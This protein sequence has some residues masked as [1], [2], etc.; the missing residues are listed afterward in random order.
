VVCYAELVVGQI[1]VG[2][3]QLPPVVIGMLVLIL[4]TQAILTRV[5]DRLR[6]HPHEL[7][8]IYVMMLLASMISSRGLLQKLVPLLVVPNYLAT[9]D[10]GWKTHFYKFIRPWSVP[11][12]PKGEPKQ[13]VSARFYEGL[14]FGEHIPWHLWLRPLFSWGV[15]ITLIFTAYLCLA[16]ILRRQWVDN[17]KLAFPLVQLPLEMVRGQSSDGTSFLTNR[18]TWLGFLLPALLFGFNGLHQWYPSIPDVATDIDLNALFHDRPWNG[19]TY[20][21]IYLSLAALGFFYLLPTDLLFSFWFFFL[22]TKVEEVG[23]SALGYEPNI[24]PLAGCK[25]FIG[26][27]IIGCYFVL[28]GTMIYSARSHLKRVWRHAI[29]FG[30]GGCGEDAGE[31]FSYRT[32]FWGLAACVLLSAGWMSLLGMAYWL[33]LI[34]LCILIFIVA[35]VMARSTCEGG[36]LMTETSF[37]PVDIF[38]MFGDVRN[39]GG[40]NLTCMAFLDGLLMRDLRGL[41]LTGFLDSMK[42][43]DGVRVRRRSLLGVFLLSFAVALGVSGC[44][45]IVLPYHRGAIT[46]YSYVYRGNPVWAFNDASSV[47]AGQRPPLSISATI[48]CGIGVIITLAMAALRAQLPW[49]PFHPLGYALSGSW[50]VMVFWFPCLVAWFCKGVILRYGGKR[51][52]LILRPFFLGLVLGEFTMAVLWTIPSLFYNT[53]TPSFPWP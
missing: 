28:V 33:A 52:Y 25:E 8:T 47:L 26:Y 14:R 6:L 4:G 31:L 51:L 19:M 11:F 39:L 13:F 2:F 35:L 40:G 7:F 23:A 24:M 36:M 38:R 22:L 12:D 37:R 27:Q 3:L 21:H 45:H 48:W 41:I 30:R 53:P 15:F 17:E 46:M 50:S 18:L 1:Q 9:D 44:L 16:V 10:N 32:A 20:F 34:E 43:A 5:N 42:F 29:S 49:F